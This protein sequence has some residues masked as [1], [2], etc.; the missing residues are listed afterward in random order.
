MSF[1]KKD[2]DNEWKKYTGKFEF[3]DNKPEHVGKNLANLLGAIFKD[4]NKNETKPTHKFLNETNKTIK[5]FKKKMQKE[6]EK[7]LSENLQQMN[8]NPK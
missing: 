5:N 8:L 7:E 3:T 4:E 6:K 1:K 2:D